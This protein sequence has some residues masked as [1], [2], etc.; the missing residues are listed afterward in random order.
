MLCPPISVDDKP[1]FEEEFV[2][3]TLTRKSADKEKEEEEKKLSCIDQVRFSAETWGSDLQTWSKV[4]LRAF[5]EDLL[6]F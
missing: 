6:T 2:S 4:F 1:S 3:R 5:C